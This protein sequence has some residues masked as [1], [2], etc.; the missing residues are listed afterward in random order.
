MRSGRSRL[1]LWLGLGVLR[2][3]RM[4]EVVMDDTG[5]LYALREELARSLGRQ[6]YDLWVGSPTSLEWTASTLRVGCATLF[7]MQWL[8]RRLH[9]T[10]LTCCHKVGCAEVEIQYYVIAASET[11]ATPPKNETQDASRPMSSSQSNSTQV[12]QRPSSKCEGKAGS[13]VAAPGHTHKP[14]NLQSRSTFNN[15]VVGKGNELAFRTAQAIGEQLGHYGPLLLFGSPGVGKTHLLFAMLQHLR[16]AAT[17]IRVLR[18]TAEQFTAEFLD[19]LNRRALPS[20][21][22]KYR[23]IDVLLI[24]DIQFL[25][26]KRATLDELL[27]TL[28]TLHERGCQ[29]ILTSDRSPGDLQKLSAELV[30]RISGGLAIP[31][32]PP[33]Y[34]TRVGIVRQLASQRK[35]SLD[36]ETVAL[37]ASQVLGSARQLSGAI[38]RLL[39]TSQSLG[40]S[41]TAETARTALAEFVQQSA[42]A[43]RLADIQ[44]AVCEVFGVEAASLKSSRKSRSVAEPRM[45]AMWLARKY[46]RSA[47]GEIGEFFG[48]RSHS[49]VISAQR[50]I[51][52]LVSQG[53]NIS[54]ADRPC[55]VEEA[56][57]QVESV[58]RT[59]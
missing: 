30:S 25:I 2:V 56:I 16:H 42:P 11:V 46:T 48:R 26:G 17:R 10:L 27:Y 4:R 6:R 52:G 40:K 22:Q 41:L 35:I 3:L 29:V 37:V 13:A 1:S 7:E 19:A 20:F 32:D 5:L 14:R 44:R 9:K 21:R 39:A 54:V 23:T 33:D 36:D 43:V 24:D 47:L 53:A 51:E 59:A 49:T 55:H 28:D 12:K 18:L 45:L 58:L 50:R 57:R 34:A 15:F 31:I 38:N 8:R